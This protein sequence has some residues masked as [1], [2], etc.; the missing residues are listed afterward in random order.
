MQTYTV[1]RGD[2]IQGISKQFGVSIEEIK[3]TNNLNSNTIKVGQI[4]QIPTVE[5]TALYVVKRGDNLYTIAKKY[6]TTIPELM[7]INNLKTTRLSIGQQLRV[8]VNSTSGNQ[9]YIVY[10]VK[11]GD[12]LYSIASSYNI[13]VLEIKEVNSLASNLLSIGQQLKIPISLQENI[14]EQTYDIYIVKEG[15]SLYK[16]AQMYNMEVKDLMAINNLSSSALTIGQQLKVK[17][18][19]EQQPSG[20]ECYGE[21]YIEPTYETYVVQ[22][23]DNLYDIAKRYDVTVEDI[24]TLNDLKSNNLSIGQVLKIKEA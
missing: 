18:D 8:P 1:Q 19:E 10:T 17:R 2:T 12:N 23:G 3:R 6:N 5:T 15:D 4:L 9:D 21:G 20:E 16:I 22:K 11:K 7:K 14:P 24:V 13:P